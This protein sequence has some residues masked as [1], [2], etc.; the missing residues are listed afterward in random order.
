MDYKPLVTFQGTGM[1]RLIAFLTLWAAWI[2]MMFLTACGG[3]E[4]PRGVENLPPFVRITGGP[5]EGKE[6]SFTSRIWWTGWDDDGIIDHYEFAIDPPS[7]FTP[8]E[9]D[10]PERFPEI[11]VRRFLGPEEGADTLRVSKVRDGVVFSFDYIE[12]R[13][14]S[15]SFR[16]RT[17]NPDSGQAGSLVVPLDRFSGTHTVYLRARDNEG[18]YSGT[19]HLGY[20]AVTV[21]PEGFITLPRTRAEFL[22]VGTQLT[23]RWDGTDSD[24]P[25]ANKK[26]VAYEYKLVNLGKLTPPL[27]IVP[28][29]NPDFVMNRAARDIPWTSQSAETTEVTFFLEPGS[30]LF[31]V[32]AVDMA[33]SVEPFLEYIRADGKPGNVIAFQALAGAG[34]PELTVSEPSLGRVI[35]RGQR[36][37]E[38]QVPLGQPLRFR[39][40]ATAETYGGTI[41]GFNYGVDLPDLTKEGPGSGWVGWSTFPGNIEPIRFTQAG[42]HVVYIRARDVTGGETLMILI[43]KVVEFDFDRPVLMV[44]DYK[45]GVDPRDAEHD[46]FWTRLLET[47]GR[48]DPGDLLP[49]ASRFSVHGSNDT[50]FFRPVPPKLEDLGRYR[51]IIW[52]TKGGGAD[53]SNG[54]LLAGPVTRHLGAYLRAGGK[55]WLCGEMTVASTIPT[56]TDLAD[57]DY[58]HKIEPGMF[59]WDFLKMYSDKVDNVR[60]AKLDIHGMSE[61]QPYPGRPEVFPLMQVDPTKQA[62]GLGGRFGIGGTDVII[63]PL[64]EG[65]NPKFRG[66]ID[67]LYVYQNIGVN[68]DPPR[69][70]AYDN[71]LCAI[72]WHDPDPNREQGRVIWFG[73]SMYYLLTEQA[74]ETFNRA[75]DWL[76][77]EHRPDS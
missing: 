20:T 46:A 40:S 63:D 70:S 28:S 61:V 17:P 45:D 1:R 49:E 11:T 21:T 75:V 10:A 24:S 7:A 19:D 9:I 5:P 66:Q 3:T 71:K 32:R 31:A 57:F 35:A 58:P 8:E 47:S 53:G 72:R 65:R 15:R 38:F 25:E 76:R 52:E 27:R 55:L 2:P 42:V 41:E 13:D 22:T 30:Y 74:Q 36:A 56:E 29:P 33:G 23:V 54:L 62:R 34:K 64:F 48:F 4:A 37:Y 44:D 60:Y 50:Q 51:M 6:D 16:F 39:W 12:T 69:N 67:S 43:C 26:P 18:A 77:E 68:Q 73:F 59:A 14:F